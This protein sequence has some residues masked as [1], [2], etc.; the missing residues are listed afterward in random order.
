MTSCAYP[1]GGGRETRA[2]V[3]VRTTPTHRRAMATEASTPPIVLI[4]GLWLTPRSWEGWKERFEGRGFEVLTPA[5]PHM[6]GD[7]E[8]IR[9]DPSA[10]N[11]LGVT[12]IVEHYTDIVGR[13]DRAPII[14]GQS[15]G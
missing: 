11:E 13:L 6:E 5:W 4:H 8:D 2:A 10:L 14:M 12:E 7:V 9:R 3:S 1:H 15:F